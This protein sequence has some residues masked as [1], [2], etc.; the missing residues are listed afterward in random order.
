MNAGYYTMEFNASGLSSGVYF[1]K[2]TARIPESGEEF[3]SVKKMM[4]LK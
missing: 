2:L 1:Y 4:V 3:I